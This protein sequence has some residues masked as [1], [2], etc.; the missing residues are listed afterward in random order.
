MRGNIG[1]CAKMVETIFETSA[2]TACLLSFLTFLRLISCLLLT[3][4]VFC[5][6][7]IL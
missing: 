2:E 7:G 4:G 6:C 5:Y 3:C 1:F